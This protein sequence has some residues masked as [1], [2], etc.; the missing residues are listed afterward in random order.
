MVCIDWMTAKTKSIQQ[1]KGAFVYTNGVF[2][3][4]Y[5][6]ETNQQIPANTSLNEFYQDVGIPEKLASDQAP[7]FWGCN[8]AFLKNAKG[9]GI[10][11]TY[12][13]PDRKNQIYKVDLEI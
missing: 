2:T 7:E 6:S 13:E 10:D 3:E 1:N 11:L 4:T 5:P 8:S 9:K 12:A